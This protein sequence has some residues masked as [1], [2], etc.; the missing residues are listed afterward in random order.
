MTGQAWS[1][2]TAPSPQASH[3]EQAHEAFKSWHHYK[4][5]LLLLL[6]V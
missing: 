1:K 2:K 3:R 6:L 4:S 5:L